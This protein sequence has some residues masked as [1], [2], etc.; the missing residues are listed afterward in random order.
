[1]SVSA[2]GQPFNSFSVAS[3]GAWSRDP[4]A[5]ELSILSQLLPARELRCVLLS[6]EDF[7]FQFFLS[8]LDA[9]EDE[10]GARGS[11]DPG[12]SILSQL[13]LVMASYEKLR[14][15]NHFQFFLSC[16]KGITGQ[17]W[18][19]VLWSALSILSQLPPSGASA[20]GPPRSAWLSILSQLP[21]TESVIQ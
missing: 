16:L 17:G 9:E 6:P 13:P 5:G 2:T 15:V 21:Q 10:E 11:R 14:P 3:S 19:G 18:L 1:M 7:S 20:S 8:C 4:S 12:L